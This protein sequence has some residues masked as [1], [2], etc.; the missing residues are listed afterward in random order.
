VAF[1]LDITERKQAE[2]AL[3][4]SEERWTLA[5]ETFDVGAIIATEDEQVIYWNPAAQ[6]MHGFT[7]PD[8]GIEPLERTPITFDLLTPDKSHVLALDEWP[9]RRIKR[10]EP[11]R[12]LELWLRRPDQGWEK[13]VSYSGNMVETANGERLIFLSV[14]DL[15]PLHDAQ[16]RERRYLYTL[17]HNLRAPA[18]IVKGNVDLLLE[19]LPPDC[20]PHDAPVVGAIQRGV[21]RMSGMIDDFTLVMLLQAG[22]ITLHPAP[23]A[24]APTV[25]AAMTHLALTLDPAR[26]A[27]DLPSDLPP[28][29]A[30][31]KYLR[32]ILQH[33]LENAVKFSAE[34]TPIRVA[35]HRANGDMVIAV[36]DQGIGI[37]PDDL[38]HLFD[39]FY[40]VARVRSAEGTGLGLFIVKQLV[41]MQGGHIWVKSEEGKGSTVSFSLPVA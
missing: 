22:E 31:P 13:Y 34:G 25:Q 9:M 37:A 15:T 2:A 26:V 3:R 35:A 23:V 39:R 4:R 36:T 19:I 17:A 12:N 6:R 16:E 14:Y 11:V 32:T 5:I 29:Q 8:E 40:R 38:P 28:V 41:E 27:L 7:R 1:V 18:T 30:D 33:L 21:S 24:L 10:G 20:L